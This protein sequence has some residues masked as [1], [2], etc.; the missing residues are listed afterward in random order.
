MSVMGRLSVAG[1]LRLIVVVTTGVALLLASMLYVMMEVVTFRRSL[2]EHLAVLA[3][4][5]GTNVTA[6]LSF[7][8]EDTALRL[9]SAMEAEPAIDSVYLYGPDGRLFAAF[10]RAGRKVEA[11]MELHPDTTGWTPV[12]MHGRFYHRERGMLGLVSPV[13]LDGEQIGWIYLRASMAGLYTQLRW[14]LPLVVLIMLGATA[15]AFILASRLQRHISGPIQQLVQTMRRVSEE[16]DYGLRAQP[17]SND[18]IGALIEGFNEMLVQ[19][20]QREQRLARHREDLARQVEARTAELSQ[21][22][23]DLKAAIAEANRAREAAE[24]ANQAKS[25]FL[26][27]MSHEIRTPMNGILG[28]ADLLLDTALERRQREFTQTIERSAESLLD[29]IDDILNFAKVESGRLELERVD[30]DLRDLVEE[31]LELF[32]GRAHAKGIELV[33]Y[34][35]ARVPARMRGDPARIRQIFTNLVSNAVK[36]TEQ[37]QVVVWVDAEHW[38]SECMRVRIQVEDTGIGL[39]PRLQ[40]HVFEAFTQADGSTTRR[41]GGTGLGL[42]IAKQL[43][44]LMGGR[45]GVES[46]PGK[47]SRF[48]V[49]LPLARTGEAADPPSPPEGFRG[50]RVLVV[51]DRETNR[52]ILRRQGEAWGLHVE[53]V[54]DATAALDRMERACRAGRPFELLLVDQGMPED[55]G[56]ALVRK[57]RVHDREQLRTTPVILLCASQWRTTQDDAELG[58][59]CVATRPVREAR[60]RACVA[61]ALGLGTPVMPEPAG[62]REPAGS[63]QFSADVLLV[64]DNPINQYVATTMLRK[65]GC[66]VHLAENGCE[67]LEAVRERRFDLVLMDCLMPGMDGFEATRLIRRLPHTAGMPIVALTAN[68]TEGYRERCLLAGMDDFLGKPFK[69]DEL[70]RMLERWLN[71]HRADDAPR[72]AASGTDG[73]DAVNEET[74]AQLAAL[75]G[76]DGGPLVQQLVEVY[77]ESARELL[78]SLRAGLDQGDPERVRRA[79]H[80]LKSGSANVGAERLSRLCRELEVSSRLGISQQ[81]RELVLA[82]ESE[83]GRV[84]TALEDLIEL[85]GS[86]RSIEA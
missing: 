39:D 23:A 14:Y 35:D 32:A 83:H 16:K 74:I 12:D 79:A 82:I 45:I 78:D 85:D 77:R 26:A 55:G 31:T 28:M 64:E 41:F 2:L 17:G 9:I 57:L 52:T 10:R 62:Q 53:T 50:R 20:Q 33:S 65:F 72:E 63:M 68:A 6:A 30:F 51:D 46:E 67:A 15:V 3:D 36:F 22:N 29:L 84:L 5:M 60:L 54:A 76:K 1:K 25:E 37:G 24:A 58:L 44:E 73:T 61:E 7:D 21:A 66:V 59:A 19:I 11:G 86:E 71:G 47:G 42:A 70:R 56:V 8:D 43:V 13:M 80:A 48:W 38:D 34:V 49:V 69:L 75:G 81:T 40:D 27:R 4:V 18:E